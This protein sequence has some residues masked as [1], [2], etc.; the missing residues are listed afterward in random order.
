V[1]VCT[2]ASCAVV[3]YHSCGSCL[4]PGR[5]GH[6]SAWTIRTTLVSH[7]VSLLACSESRSPGRAVHRSRY[8]YGRAPRT[9]PGRDWRDEVL[10]AR[11]EGSGAPFR[12]WRRWPCG[13]AEPWR[14]GNQASWQG[15]RHSRTRA[16][17]P[18]R[19]GRLGL[20][21]NWR[22]S[23]NPGSSPT[24]RR[25]SPTHASRNCSRVNSAPS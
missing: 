13:N 6:A 8:A 12:S 25:C 20:D 7:G 5:R 22:A 24:S 14:F 21:G 17:R 19:T 15:H 16:S 1:T 10:M 11:Q 9:F 23:T 4:R 3:L 18:R 2:R